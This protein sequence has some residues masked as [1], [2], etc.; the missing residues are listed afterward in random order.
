MDEVLDSVAEQRRMPATVLVLV[1][2]LGL[3]LSAV[4]LYGV[5]AYGARELGRPALEPSTSRRGGRP[6]SNPRKRFAASDSDRRPLTP[7]HVSS[8][9]RQ[10]P[11][12]DTHPPGDRRAPG[13]G[14]R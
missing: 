6:G 1:G 12:V 4:G 14:C 5:M 13:P 7:Y 3:L 9:G 10:Y 8:L 11:V 2:L